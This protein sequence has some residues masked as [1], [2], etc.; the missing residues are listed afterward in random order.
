MNN[1]IIYEQPVA[2][3]IRNILKCE[4]LFEKFNSSLEQD[5]IWGI[6]SSIATLLETSDFVSRINLKIEL[7]KEL[8]KNILYIN[9]LKDVNNDKLS[10]YEESIEKLKFV[11]D[12]INSIEEN[13][14]KSVIDNDFLMQIK[15][16]IY[17]PAGDNFFDM[18]SYLNFLSS[19]KTQILDNINLWYS[20]FE[21]L[22]KASKLILSTRRKYSLFEKY[23]SS[24]S[25][26]ELK[27]NKDTYVD[28]IR[29][30]LDKD[31][32]IYPNVSVSRQNI[33]IIFKHAT[34]NKRISK[35]II[36]NVDFNLGLSGIK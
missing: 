25:Y 19:N 22:F 33:N 6:K 18:P 12:K 13:P 5:N 4:Y 28:F 35:P 31:I 29:I 20:P 15:S 11:I 16:K 30:R 3:N 10:D 14:S 27:L 21:Y 7:L 2:E 17:L 23:T 24:K 34:G 8:E 1:Y 26:F 36:E 9:N 32:N